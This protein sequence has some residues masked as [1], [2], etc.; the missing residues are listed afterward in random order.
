MVQARVVI[1]RKKSDNADRLYVLV[2]DQVV[3]FD[4]NLNEKIKYLAV[5]RHVLSA[6]LVRLNGSA[7]KVTGSVTVAQGEATL[8]NALPLEI[9]RTGEISRSSTPFTVKGK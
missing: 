4:H 3:D 7:G 9:S 2:D 8:V 5:G 6:F 1:T